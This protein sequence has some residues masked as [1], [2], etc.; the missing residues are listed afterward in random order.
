LV[1]LL[2]AFLPPTRRGEAIL[3]DLHEEFA[4]RAQRSALRARLWYARVAIGIAVRFASEARKYERRGAHYGADTRGTW[5]GFLDSFIFNIRYAIR[6][7][8][9]APM[10]ALVAI[11]SLGL[12]IGA[13]TAMFSLVNTVIIR[14]LPYKNPETLVDIYES[15]GG[16]SHATLSYPDYLSV[17]EGTKDVFEEVSGSRLLFLQVDVE[18]GV[19]IIPAESVTGNYFSLI[20]VE[21]VI[22]R[23]I[24]SEDHVSQGAH[25]VVVLGYGYWQSRFGGLSLGA[26][27]GSVVWMLTGNGMKLVALGGVIG[28]ILAAGLSQLLSRMLYGVP[29]LDPL[30]FL[31][32]PL[33]LGVVALAASWVPA[34][35]VTG[36]NPVR[37]LRAE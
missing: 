1:R 5:E 6:R 33:V 22:G 8:M 31:G 25:P 16:F 11:L 21:P 14:D 3:G 20:G 32:V 18:E 23:L 28:L 17:I 4:Q 26:E 15:F 35:R 36:I 7:L 9:R 30:T 2:R 27:A 19:E 24:T 13:N 10:F 37:A 29:A 34:R 12:G